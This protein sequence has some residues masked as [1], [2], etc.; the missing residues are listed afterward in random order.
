[1]SEVIPRL[2]PSAAGQW[3]NCPGSVAMSAQFPEEDSE[4][5]RNGTASHHAA[6]V[7]L[8]NGGHLPPAGTVAPNGVIIDMEMIDAAGVYVMAV[9]SHINTSIIHLEKKMMIP[10]I[11]PTE[12]GGT[13]D[14]WYY[15]PREKELHVWDYKYGY[16][17]V[18]PWENMQAICYVAGAL[19]YVADSIK[20]PIGLLDQQTTVI[21]H[22]VQPRP[23]HVAGPVREWRVNAA[24]L[25]GYFN[26]L[27]T[28]AKAALGPNPQ[29]ITGSWCKFCSARH[30]CIPA[31]KAALFAIEYS[32]VAAT[33]VLSPEAL[34]IE[35]RTMERAADAI[36]YRLTGLQEQAIGLLKKGQMVPGYGLQM[37]YGRKS[38]VKPAAE[39][40]ALGMLMGIDLAKPLEAVTPAQAKKAGIPADLIDAYSQ[41]GETGISLVQSNKTLATM[42]FT[43]NPI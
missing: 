41:V 5:S 43:Q 6:Y 2:R 19:D 23:F 18:E 38:W 7:A 34:A 16:I 29:C 32:D 25:R 31:Q 3:L 36:K 37:G 33:C 8:S 17:L 28:S 9:K 10:Y 40:L 12:C 22:I 13:P 35:L 1:M 42:A 39:V 30:A 26:R 27:Q 4:A 14:C 11:H 15:N 20:M 24:D 21:I